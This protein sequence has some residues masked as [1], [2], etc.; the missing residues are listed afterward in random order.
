MKNKILRLAALTGC[1]L[2]SPAAVAEG[3]AFDCRKA[4]G[5]VEKVICADG[6]LSALDR[7]LAATYA[8]ARRQAGNEHPPVL[9]AGQRGWI[10]GRNDCWKSADQRLCIATAYRLRIA[11]LQARYRLIPV[12]AS[13]RFS[14]DGDPRNEVDVTYFRTDPPSLIAERGDSV[15]LMFQQPGASGAHYQGSNES[16]REHQGEAEIVWGYG[17]PV[18]RCQAGP[19]ASALAGTTWELV[20]IQS[21]DDAQGTTPVGQPEQFTVSFNVDGRASFRI[22]C[23]RATATWTVTPSAEAGSGTLEFGPLAS[24]RAMCP[25]AS[26]ERK[27]ISNLPYVRS[28]RLKDSRLYM[29][30]FADGGIYEWRRQAP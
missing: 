27:L 30:L 14:C 6:D 17:A 26:V 1:V 5:S 15:A 25:A 7:S 28:Y 4:S 12:A 21:M 9:R 24:T 2:A 22:D 8:A 20:A 10:K 29:S 11:E 23:N 16:L 19:A 13:A 18:M 3:P